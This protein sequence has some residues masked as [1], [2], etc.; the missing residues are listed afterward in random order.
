MTSDRR[1]YSHRIAKL[2][3]YATLNDAVVLRLEKIL[4]SF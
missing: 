3:E 4:M 2:I 1:L